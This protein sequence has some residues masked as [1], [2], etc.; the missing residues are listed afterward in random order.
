MT[1]PPDTTA[2]AG[3]LPPPLAA[4]PARLAR[5]WLILGVGALALA[6]VFAILIVAART[7]AVDE[8]IPW[9]NFF[10]TALVVHV[11]LSVWFLAFAGVLWSVVGNAR[12]AGV[13]WIALGFFAAGTLTIA[14]SAFTGSPSPLMNNYVPVLDQPVF[15]AGLN[16]L[17]LGFSALVVRTL[18]AGVPRW[19]WGDAFDAARFGAYAG[20]LIALLALFALGATYLQIG[21]RFEG[22]AYF[23][24]L[25]WSGGHT[26]QFG[27]TLLLLLAWLWLAEASGVALGV[28]ARAAYALLA[29]AAAPALLSP[30]LQLGTEFM[31]AD[32]HLGFTRLMEF[33][34]L[35]ALPL[36]LVVAWGVLRAGRAPQTAR[37]ER[38]ALVASLVLFTAGGILGFL[39]RGVN[40]VIPAHYHG[41]IVGITLAFMGCTY[42]L[43]PRLGYGAPAPRMA[44]A[45]AYVYG[46]GQL[47]HILGLAWSGGYGVA[48]KTAGAAQGLDDFPRIAG[49]A[50]M[51]LGG[52]IAIIGGLLFVIV[53]WRAMRARSGPVA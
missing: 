34:G 40:V 10:R 25:F 19:R 16:L 47:L 7:P 38:A 29:L 2:S 3:F 50:L 32:F 48:R 13:G 17:G 31:S 30:A 12:A 46:G 15:L 28:T 8:H 53:V 33:G 51:G 41:S 14:A 18:I 35:A 22:T 20:A 24:T 44:V 49:M 21:K 37:P 26:L 23:E 1:P 36:G 6:G 43:L 5:A 39:I 4:L 27:H 52:L 11:D 9:A 45:Q 42:Y